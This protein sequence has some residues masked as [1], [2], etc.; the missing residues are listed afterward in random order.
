MDKEIDKE[1]L[2]KLNPIPLRLSKQ[3]M[4]NGTVY[5]RGNV[6]ALRTVDIQEIARR[7]VEDR[8]EVRES[9]FI[10]TYGLIKEQ[11]YEALARGENVDLGFGQ[12]SIRVKGQFESVYDSFN[13]ERNAFN[14][15][16]TPSART[17]QLEQHLRAYKKT[18][19]TRRHP[20]LTE[21]CT[22]DS[23]GNR[24]AAFNTVRSDNPYIHLIGSN[25]KVMGDHPDCKLCFRSADGETVVEPA[26]LVLNERNHL[27]AG[28][29]PRSHPANGPRNWGRS[30]SSPITSTKSLVTR[31][32]TLPLQTAIPILYRMSI[33]LIAY[34]TSSR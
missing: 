19:P 24:D 33:I 1:R 32:A 20:V 12:L 14:I 25:I 16:F 7:I 26:V 3:T 23:M 8:S 18:E 6:K 29:A 4:P 10:H 22:Y 15:V 5:Y 9:T 17:R 31:A 21:V 2:K 27:L 34:N 13:P 30:S 11:I 28:S